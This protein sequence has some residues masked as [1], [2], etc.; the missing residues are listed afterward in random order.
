VVVLEYSTILKLISEY[1]N[2]DVSPAFRSSLASLDPY[3]AVPKVLFNLPPP[4]FESYSSSDFAANARTVVAW[5]SKIVYLLGLNQLSNSVPLL[6]AMQIN[7]YAVMFLGLILNIM[8]ILLTA[9]SI[10]LIYSLLLISVESRTFELGVLRMVGLNRSG[11]IQMLLVH[12]LMFAIPAW[13]SGLLVSQGFFIVV[14]RVLYRLSDVQI[15][16]I[17]TGTSLAVSSVLGL[18]IPLVSSIFPIRSALT[19]NLH[20]SLDTLRSKTKAMKITVERSSVH[21]NLL[22]VVLVGF[23]L[24]TFGFVIY[25]ILPLSLVNL[26]IAMLFNIFLAIM[27]C[28]LGGLVLL[29]LNV[30]PMLE[31]L[32][33]WIMFTFVLFFEN[34]SIP[35]I[36]KKNLVS[37]RQRNKKT[38]ISYATSL[39]FIIFLAVAMSVELR[40]LEDV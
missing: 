6:D 31:A 35:S 27:L 14:T 13:I 28:M 21:E 32:F 15:S 39:G 18:G 5:S 34:K 25:Y 12:A 37:H 4:R 26:N 3:D 17:L 10:L 2:P 8:T 29:S 38:A 36:I 24:V 40:T 23:L 7:T 30:Q 33:I 20:D 19:Q 22:P 11:L 1:L 9:I 16:P